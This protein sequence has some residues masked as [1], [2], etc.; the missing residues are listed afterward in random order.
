MKVY[1][2]IDETICYY[3]GLREYELAIPIRENIKKVN[4][5]FEEGHEI[6]YWT[7]R[8][9]TT[10]IDWYNITKDQLE[11]WNCK[12]HILS[13]GEKPDYD[14]LICDKAHNSKSFF[15]NLDDG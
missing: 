7:A 4:K 12:Y 1:V 5:L 15:S 13:V 6:T 9:S 11:K 10:G 8:G 3:D 2:D 14:I